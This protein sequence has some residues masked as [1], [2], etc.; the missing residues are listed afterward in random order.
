M[1]HEQKIV[2]LECTGVFSEIWDGINDKRVRGVVCEG[3][4]RSSKTWSICQA[5]LTLGHQSQ[6]RIII[7]RFRR[8]WIKP[9][10]LDTFI[11]VC[12][13]LDLWEE[14]AFNK[15][16]LIYSLNGSTYEFYG[17]D[18][19]QKLHGIEADYF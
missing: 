8:T 13:S 18:D 14:E 1:I 4:S 16:E 11:K 19:S 5:L 17:L 6:T 3:G 15:T 2:D 10:V 7:A 12:K 9:T